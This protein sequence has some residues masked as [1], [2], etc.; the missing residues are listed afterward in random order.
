M[1]G[2]AGDDAALT[3]AETGVSEC[4]EFEDCN[5]VCNIELTLSQIPSGAPRRG[6][7]DAKVLL[8]TEA[9]DPSSGEGQAFSGMVARR[10]LRY[11]TDP[12][13]GI[14]L[15][16]PST[17]DPRFT[18]FLQHHR[19]Y[20]T[21]AIKCVVEGG[22][23]GGGQGVDHEATRR[24]RSQFLLNQISAHPNAKILVPM[25]KVA[26]SSVLHSLP[27]SFQLSSILGKQN[28]GVFRED[29]H[30][31]RKTVVLPH[32]SGSSPLSNPPTPRSSDSRRT[33]EHKRSFRKALLA[34]REFLAEEGYTVGEAP[35]SRWEHEE[36][37][38]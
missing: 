26:A 13:Y 15:D 33:A 1:V 29:P 6:S 7:R 37:W 12:A 25:G 4:S 16:E 38:F 9:P 30:F 24:C 27:S 8:V 22:G 17:D 28:A 32:P 31:G 21:S 10:I 35:G 2:S 14:D 23:G 20:A 3:Q 11:F 19:F 5:A 34:L 36:P 18:A